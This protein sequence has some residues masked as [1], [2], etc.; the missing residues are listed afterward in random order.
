MSPEQL[1][2]SHLKLLSLPTMVARL[3]PLVD[4]PTTSAADI[5]RVIAQDAALTARLLKIVNCPF[6]RLPAK[7][8]SLDMALS[9]LDTHQLRDLVLSAAV[10]K[11]FQTNIDPAFDVEV[12]WCH[13]ITTAIAARLL[14]SKMTL[15]NPERF[16]VTGLLHDIGKMVMYLTLPNESFRL[17]Q[18]LE[19]PGCDV[20]NIEQQ[21]FGF[22]HDDVG[23]ALLKAWNF[24]ESI[25]G[26]VRY[27]ALLNANEQDMQD[28]ALLHIANNIANN[29]QE[30]I[31]RDD[32]TPLNQK[33][34]EVL[35]LTPEVIEEVYEE[36]Y[37]HLD[38]LL[39]IFY[40]DLVT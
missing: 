14:A 33:A 11:R 19:K 36:T 37:H 13:S 9:V 1:I 16:F 35:Q 30:P 40:Y 34:T 3:I 25:I 39:E 6:Y 17:I 31:S 23:V 38:E 24:P 27:H 32:D 28:A 18:E 15:A 26:P 8:D 5:A 20:A 10:I 2:H 22:T 21:L 29:M 12:F 7:I 4:D